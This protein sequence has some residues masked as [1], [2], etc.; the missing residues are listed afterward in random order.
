[1]VRQSMRAGMTGRNLRRGGALFAAPGADW[2]AD[3]LALASLPPEITFTRA[4]NATRINASGVMETVGT[5]VAR[6]DYDPSTLALRGL[7]ME[8][9]RTN[10]HL[11]SSAI[12]NGVWTKLAGAAT[13]D[14][15]VA[16]DGTMTADDFT[17]N[18][19]TGTHSVYQSMGVTSGLS[20]VFSVYGKTDD[21]PLI[22]LG[23]NSPVAFGNASLTYFDPA[24]TSVRVMP[25]YYTG[26]WMER[27]G[28][29]MYRFSVSGPAVSTTSTT[30][31]RVYPG[32][33]TGPSSQTATIDFAVN[34][35]KIVLWGSDLQVGSFPT[36]HIPTAGTAATRPA[37]TAIIS[38]SNFTTLCG[39]SFTALIDVEMLGFVADAALISFSDGTASNRVQ[40]RVNATGQGN[41][42]VVSSGSG[43]A[44]TATAISGAPLRRRAV[45][46]VG[47][48][49][50]RLF[51]NGV[52]CG[53]VGVIPSG[54]SQLRIMG[55]QASND[56]SGHVRGVSIWRRALTPEQARV[57]SLVS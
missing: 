55:G 18:S 20:Y 34:P 48:G 52:D 40:A 36:S 13:A 57:L 9:S 1:M 8:E 32:L 26:A 24:E 35:G 15:A 27:A 56:A 49:N 14:T 19:G 5:D 41:L 51:Q 53:G 3:F 28:A 47:N 21:Y 45:L 2:R 7:L 6:F 23:L 46:V 39:T 50:V 16:P 11:W 4:G 42:R 44:D 38:G 22:A 37:E 33:I 12:D 43:I 30:G 29:S 31:V 54:L 10:M 25:A 17:V